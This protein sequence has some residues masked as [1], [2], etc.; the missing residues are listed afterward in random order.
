MLND[1]RMPMHAQEQHAKQMQIFNVGEDCPVFSR[2]FQYCQVC[3]TELLLPKSEELMLGIRYCRLLKTWRIVCKSKAV[4][5]CAAVCGSVRWRR[6]E[7]ELWHVGCGH[8][9]GWWPAPCQEERGGD[10]VPELIA[11]CHPLGHFQSLQVG[12]H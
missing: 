7:S 5:C 2:Q 6:S 3:S 4:C 1:L 12:Q 8:Q 9:L 10:N 11:F